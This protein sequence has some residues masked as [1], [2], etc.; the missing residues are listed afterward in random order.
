MED[1]TKA[2]QAEIDGKPV[3][4]NKGRK[5]TV[6]GHVRAGINYNVLLQHF[7]DNI[8][9]RINNGDKVKVFQLKQNDFDFPT[10]AFP[11]EISK[12]PKWFIDNFEID[13]KLSEEKLISAKLEGIFSSMNQEVPTPQLTHITSIVSF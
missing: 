2:Y 12:F 3:K 5:I 13:L 8:S 11:G 6:P 4:N 1:F 9:S 10:I 7:E